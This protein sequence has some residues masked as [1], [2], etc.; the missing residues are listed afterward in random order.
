M[1]RDTDPRHWK[2]VVFYYDP[3]EPRLFVP[4]WT[5]LPFTLNFAR[6]TA[7]AI[8]GTVLAILTVLAVLNN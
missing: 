4:K 2:L 1:A 8:T 3:D 6:P 7:W 5:G